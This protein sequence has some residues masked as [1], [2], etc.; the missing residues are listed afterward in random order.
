M[1]VVWAPG[2]TNKSYTDVLHSGRTFYKKRTA[3][4]ALLEAL[5]CLRWLESTTTAMD[6]SLNCDDRRK[7]GN[8][9]SDLWEV[10]ARSL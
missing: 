1:D 3:G 5:G 6:S 4:G 9:T 8:H 7:F 10:A 2:H